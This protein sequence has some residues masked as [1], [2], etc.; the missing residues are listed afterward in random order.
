MYT[1]NDIYHLIANNTLATEGLNHELSTT[2]SPSVPTSHSISEIY[3]ALANLPTQDKL[4]PDSTYLGVSQSGSAPT[5]TT[6]TPAS[7]TPSGSPSITGYTLNDIWNLATTSGTRLTSPS[8]H[9][10]STTSAPTGTMHTLKEIYLA[11]VAYGDAHKSDVLNTTTYL[12]TLGTYVPTHTVTFDANTGTGSMSAQ[13]IA[14]GASANLTSNTFTKTGNNF[15]GWATTAG[16]VV[17]YADAA[18]YTM[19][20]SNVTLYAK[21]AIN[22]TVTFDANT[23]SGS[24]SPQTIAE[25]ASANLTANTFTK[26]GNTF[27]GWATTA[28]GDVAYADTASYTMGSSNVTLYAKWTAV[29]DAC[30]VSGDATD[31]DC[32]SMGSPISMAWGPNPSYPGV[33]TDIGLSNGK[34]NT[35]VLMAAESAYSES[36]PAAH[37]CATLDDGTHPVGTWYLPSYA[38]LW[39][40]YGA[41]PGF[42]GDAY[43]SSTEWSQ[44][45]DTCAWAL[46]P[47]LNDIYG[48]S[49][50]TPPYNVRCLR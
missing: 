3:A 40:G 48:A 19:G 11:L 15:S 43:W 28:G 33:S 30:G 42:M 10:L 35:D 22:Y 34:A 32:W 31:L 5:P 44:M 12:G 39:A 37:Y 9:S 7:L 8:S 23:G 13:T 1:L 47:G 36:Y 14:E 29:V 16:G 27:A 41:V 18:S 20:S 26:T 38:E 6:F 46:Y 49:K 4:K 24:M 17:A 50:D 25:G 2:S 45:S 21:W